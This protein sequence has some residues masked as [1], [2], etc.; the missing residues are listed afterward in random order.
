MIEPLVL[1]AAKD[2]LV[3]DSIEHGYAIVD[4]QFLVNQWG[5]TNVA[6]ETIER[7]SPINAL[8]LSS[9]RPDALVAAPN[10]SAFETSTEQV[11]APLLSVIEAKGHSAGSVNVAEAITQAHAHLDE[12][13]LGFAA[14]PKRSIKSIHRRLAG[15]LDVGVL[16]VDETGDVEVAEKPRAVGA[17]TTPSTETVRFHARIGGDVPSKLKKNHPKNALGYILAVTADGNTETLCEE[18][19]IETVSHAR[20]DAEALG[21]VA[22]GSGNPRLTPKGTESVRTLSYCYDGVVAA[23]N[24]IREYRRSRERLIDVEP[25]MAIVAR[26]AIL[27]YPP[28]QELLHVLDDITE[29]GSG[30]FRVDQVAKRLAKRRP[31]FAIDLFLSTDPK[32]R[33]TALRDQEIRLEVFDQEEHY[34]TNTLYQY[35]AVLFHT[36]L[37]T[38]RGLDTLAKLDFSEEK[39]SQMWIP[40]VSL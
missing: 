29:E 11:L 7:L 4:A 38:S 1:A 35:K 3:T 8:N 17:S 33:R 16:L 40:E 21:L 19:V 12:V 31:E 2:Y 37:L 5:E 23:L 6:D 15:E 32:I 14:V 13:N 27:Q 34:H 25:A 24:K 28:T 9:G 22:T 30:R 26:D 18:Y 39:E 10:P 20:L 36:G